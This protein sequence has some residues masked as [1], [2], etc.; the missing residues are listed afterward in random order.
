MITNREIPLLVEAGRVNHAPR[1]ITSCLPGSVE[2]TPT[3]VGY[4]TAASFFIELALRDQG[5]T[6]AGL[7]F[8]VDTKGR[9]CQVR[10]I[11]ADMHDT[12]RERALRALGDLLALSQNQ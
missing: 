5:G 3:T 6:P 2:I 8:V 4:L 10:A 12:Y 7:R 1:I 11:D 9:G